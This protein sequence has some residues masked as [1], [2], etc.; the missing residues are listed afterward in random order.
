MDLG[1]L[2][3]FSM[4]SRRMDWLGDRQRVLAQNIAN[5][6]TPGYLP[7]DLKDLS[8]RSLLQPRPSARVDLAATDPMHRPGA[9]TRPAYGER[10]V[11]E[12]ELVTLSG[13]AVELEDELRKVSETSV[14]YQTMTNLYRK[15]V[16]LIKTA[17]GRGGAV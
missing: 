7:R 2:R 3:L 10:T 9:V 15:H 4:L 12:D 17:L 5:A 6:D 13:N 16:E 1:G 11:R 14:D 8:F